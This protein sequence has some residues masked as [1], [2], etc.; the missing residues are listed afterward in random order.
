MMVGK[1]SF[2]HFRPESSAVVRKHISH[3]QEMAQLEF[4][5]FFLNS[6]DFRSMISVHNNKS[7]RLAEEVQ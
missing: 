2:F 5:R 6:N 4:R 3:K 1:I 7:V